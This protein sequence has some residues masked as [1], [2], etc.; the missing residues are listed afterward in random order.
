MDKKLLKTSQN[1]PAVKAYKE[2]VRKGME[3]QHVIPKNGSWAVKKAG[4]DKASRIFSKKEEAVNF[5]KIVASN[6]G[7]ALFVHGIDG[8]IQERMYQ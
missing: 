7:T 8:R 2:A 5:A 6:Q 3:S 4:S 1:H